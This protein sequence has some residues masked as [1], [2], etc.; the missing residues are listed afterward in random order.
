MADAIEQL[1]QNNL[2]KT[3]FLLTHAAIPAAV[4]GQPENSGSKRLFNA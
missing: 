3:D 2:K 4:S 1:T